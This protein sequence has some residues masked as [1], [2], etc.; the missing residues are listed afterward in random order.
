[1]AGEIKKKIRP[2][3][4]VLHPEEQA[5]VVNYETQELLLLPDGSSTLQ[6]RLLVALEYNFWCDTSP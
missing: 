3:S 6:V 1:M 5:L 4:I 2:G